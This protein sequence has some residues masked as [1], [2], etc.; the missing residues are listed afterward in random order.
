M[1]RL[2]PDDMRRTLWES[3]PEM[4]FINLSATESFKAR[5]PLLLVRTRKSVAALPL[6][7]VPL[8]QLPFGQLSAVT[9]GGVPVAY[10]LSLPSCRIDIYR[11]CVAVNLRQTVPEPA[12]IRRLFNDGTML[13]HGCDTALVA[14]LVT[15]RWLKW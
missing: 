8:G 6:I 12:S 3:L 4:T 2:E 15:R 5:H 11:N 10:G 1:E 9:C 7:F 14:T 13:V